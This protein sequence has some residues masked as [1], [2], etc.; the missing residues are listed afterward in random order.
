MAKK[1]NI[2]HTV[3]DSPANGTSASGL[4]ADE[5]LV[6]LGESGPGAPEAV[7][8]N[9]THSM[10]WRFSYLGADRLPVRRSRGFG[11]LRPTRVTSCG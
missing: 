8:R 5:R 1:G 10:R 4:P 7:P 11:A 6:S 3:K 9:A 2:P